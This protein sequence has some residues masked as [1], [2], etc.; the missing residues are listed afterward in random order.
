MVETLNLDSVGSLVDI[1][2]WRAQHQADNM[3]YTF[4]LDGGTQEISVTYAE[5]DRRARSIGAWL[6]SA[7]AAGE[8][9]LLLYP[10]GL[11]YIAAFLGCLYAKAVAVPAYPPRPKRSP[12]RLRSICNDA[13]PKIALATSRIISQIS[14]MPD[15]PLD[16]KGIRWQATDTIEEG[17]A[18]RWRHT[19]ID[20]QTLTFLQYT[21]GST[22]RPKGVMVSHANLLHNERIIQQAFQQTEHSIIVGWLPLYHDMGLI[23]NVLQPL[24]VGA[25]SILLSPSAF[26]QR[27]LSW[28]EMI[29]RY[30]ATTS[31][32]PNFAYDLCVRR[33]HPQQLETLNLDSWSVA[34]NGSEPIQKETLD[35]FA[36]T[37]EPCGFRWEAFYSCYG[38]AEATLFVTGS[39]KMTRPTVRALRRTALNRGYLVTASEDRHDVRRLVGCGSPWPEHRVLIVDPYSLT[40]CPPDRVGEIWVSG[41]SVAQ[42][43][44]NRPEETRR[45]FRADLVDTDEGPFLR[46]GDLGFI[47]DDELYVTGRLKD[48]IIIRGRNH[49]P[50][51]IERTVKLCCPAAQPDL[52]A[53][54]SIEVGGEERLVVVREVEHSAI[55]SDVEGMAAAIR[56]AVAEEHELQVH[57]IVL[58]EPRSIPVTSSGKIRRHACRDRFMEGKLEVLWSSVPSD[59]DDPWAASTSS[60][61][62]EIRED[63]L[64]VKSESERRSLL[65]AFLRRQAASFLRIDESDLDP[66]RP[67]TAWG[68]DSLTAIELKHHLESDLGVEISVTSLLD[69][70]SIADLVS[71]APA[72]ATAELSAFPTPSA[73]ACD[74]VAEYSL[75]HGQRGIWFLHQL[76]PGAATYNLASAVR[77]RGAINITALH[78]AFQEL[79]NRHP[80]LRTTFIVSNGQ[81]VQRVHPRQTVSFRQLDASTWEDEELSDRVAQEALRPFDLEQGPL[82]CVTVFLTPAAECVL[83]LNVHH[84][85][86]DFWSLEILMHELSQFY[87]AEKRGLQASLPHLGAQYADY[88]SW[89]DGM[90]ADPGGKK[91]W[92]YWQKQLSGELPVVNLPTDRPRPPV[93]TYAG[94]SHAF[95]LPASLTERLKSLAEERRMTIYAVL[96]AVFQILLHR[97]TGQENILVGSPAAGR[98][99][100][101]FAGIIG[102]FIN[103][104]VLRADLSG[105]PALIEFLQQMRL[106]AHAALDHH[107]FPFT[108]LTEHLQ[109]ERDPSRHPLFQV[110]FVWQKARLLGNEGLAVLALGDS[111]AQVEVGELQLES[112]ALKRRVAQFEL[113]LMMAEAGG[114]LMGSLQYN[115]DLFDASTIARMAG[116]FQTLLK[117][118]IA[119]SSQR[120]SDIEILTEI[121]RS[122]ILEEWNNEEASYPRDKLIHQLITAQAERTPD[123][124]ALVFEDEMLSYRALNRRANQLAYYLRSLGLREGDPVGIFMPRSLQMLVGLVGILKAGSCYLP[125]DPTHPGDLLEF[126]LQD[127]A[128]SVV[129]TQLELAHRLASERVIAICLDSEWENITRESEENPIEWATSDQLAYLIFTSGSTGRPKAV[130]VE[131]RNVINFFA[132]MDRRISCRSNDRMLAVTNLS[133]DI[134]ILELLWTLTRGAQVVLIDEQFNQKNSVEPPSR[135]ETREIRFSLFYFASAD[136]DSAWN[137]YRL[138]FE[139]AKFADERGFEAIWTPE[140]HFHA[141]GGLYPNPSVM[142]AALAAVTKRLGIRA[143]SVVLPLHHPVRVAEEW[144]LVDNLSHGRI[145]VS[146]ASGWHADDFVFFPN[147]YSDRKEITHRSLEIVRKLWRGES[148][149][150]TGGAGNEIEVKILPRPIQPELPIWITAAGNRDTFIKAGEIGANLLTHLLGQSL[151]QLGDKISLYRESLA[152]HGYDPYAGRVT[153]MLHTFVG[154]NKEAV[155]EKV[156]QPFIKYLRSSVDL[157][158]N[159]ISSLKLSLDLNTMSDKDMDDLLAFAFDRYFETSA[160]FGTP[161]TCLPLIDRLRE[162]GCDEVACLIDF[163]VDTDSVLAS[164]P[165]LNILKDLAN[166]RRGTQEF[167]IANQA[168]RWNPSLMQC[169]PSM[170]KMLGYTSK[171]WDFLTSLKTLMLGGEALPPSLARQVES[172]LPCRVVNMYGPTETTIWSATHEVDQAPDAIPIG[173]P[174]A[175]TQ[176]YISGFNLRPQPVGVCGELYIGGDGV[177][178]GYLNR[179]QLTAEKFLPDPFSGKPGARLY[180]TGDLARYQCSGSIEFIGRND[181]QVKIRGFRV[182]LKEIEARLGEYPGLRESI[183]VA[184]EDPAGNKQLVAYVVP[185]EEQKLDVDLLRSY[186]KGR[187]PDYMAPTSI[188]V[189]KSAPLTANGKVNRKLLP[190]PDVNRRDLRVEY[191]P[192]VSKLERTIAEVWQSVLNIEKVGLE[193]N[194]FG[195][196]GH[197]LL[198]AQVHGQLQAVLN[199]DLPLVKLLEYPTISSLARYLGGNHEDP[200]SLRRSRERASQQREA[201]SRQR[202]SAIRTRRQ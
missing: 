90:L 134:S 149:R 70:V 172:A 20:G 40:R 28:L 65:E 115:T 26:L 76:A 41:P 2:R 111:G 75:A 170:M 92:A 23:G 146:L 114:E 104:I 160:V 177:A 88:V 99:L 156:R 12:D 153:L 194:F 18:E 193:D 42:G 19:V 48:L 163:G 71:E 121:E 183:V 185:V 179:P 8:R 17:L 125:L 198:M 11:E 140:R 45:V 91:A 74:A 61:G 129:L 73:P 59:A 96:L 43:Y 189:L 80:C 132:G 167:S 5:L 33:A 147:N 113:T 84:L 151:E 175:N 103:P 93:Q 50:E 143:G 118:A 171:G 180:A 200:Q 186:L 137:T 144:A 37:F 166:R 126:V 16:M 49:Y 101:K 190:A 128:V 168:R 36:A 187:L 119:D 154:D 97:Y 29:S 192:P 85:V 69:G 9:V 39:L 86:A 56:Q 161:E 58:V 123:S 102:Y 57:A 94:A 55:K 100:A 105:N 68:I 108:L 165:K 169:T 62:H 21:S 83:L 52:S 54:F 44:W 27:P 25:R 35:R 145:G 31:G 202:L 1:L 136:A 67:L 122:Q 82:I 162:I 148:V 79:V 131:H 60:P 15:Q 95:K 107:D 173:R 127:T 87:S 164:L 139:G 120:V 124:I 133:F 109:V 181:Y 77:M 110:M 13:R 201:L 46:T 130:M 22:A 178:R 150:M 197:S 116:H 51:D 47:E 4:V 38:L 155:R 184:L 176:I 157:I 135:R 112:F 14:S 188:I 98:S 174:I 81:P 72:A 66:Q 34:F 182:E 63:A 191:V 199:R 3:A 138:L 106:T 89:Q 7:E 10:Q 159:L 6:Q 142:S 152:R 117:G 78:R 30:R 195:L 32:G 24:Y 53:A 64:A 141:F 196:G 158:A